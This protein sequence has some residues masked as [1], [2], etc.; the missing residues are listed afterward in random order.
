[1]RAAHI[2]LECILVCRNVHWP[3]KRGRKQDL[4]FP[5]VPIT[6]HVPPVPSRV[7]RSKSSVSV[8]VNAPL[9]FIK[10]TINSFLVANLDCGK[11]DLI[12]ALDSSTTVGVANWGQMNDFMLGIIDALTFSPDDVRVSEH[13]TLQIHHPEIQMCS[14]I[15]CRGISFATICAG[16]FILARPFG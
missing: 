5:I 15:S 16:E 4:L 9:I 8:N 7:N 10:L 3:E 14:S 12:F 2:L 1:M 11:V 13:K 6:F